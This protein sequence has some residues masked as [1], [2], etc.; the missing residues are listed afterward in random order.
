MS[1][2]LVIDN[3]LYQ[4]CTKCLVKY[5]V[6]KVNIQRKTCD[7]C[8]LRRSRERAKKHHRKP[9]SEIKKQ[10][11]C[12]TCGKSSNKM[13]VNTNQASGK[14]YHDTGFRYCLHCK[15]IVEI[16]KPFI[17]ENWSNSN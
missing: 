3:I 10:A 13:I 11:R 12:S 17:T 7:G 4:K 15:K 5:P 2:T 1:Q 8:R 6:E 16:P 14:I 9:E